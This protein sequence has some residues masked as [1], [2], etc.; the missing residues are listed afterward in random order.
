MD[1]EFMEFQ[2]IEELREHS[3][4]CNCIKCV[5]DV[6]IEIESDIDDLID[7]IEQ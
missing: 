6:I 1:D 7:L 4:L 5:P 3:W 2:E